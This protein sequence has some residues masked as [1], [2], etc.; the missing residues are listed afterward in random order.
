M[1]PSAVRK[2]LPRGVNGSPPSGR[3]CFGCPLPWSLGSRTIWS[4][5]LTPTHGASGSVHRRS[6]SGTRGCSVSPRRPDRA[7]WA[8]IVHSIIRRSRAFC[9]AASNQAI[10]PGECKKPGLSGDE[11]VLNER[12][13]ARQGQRR[14]RPRHGGLRA[15]TNACAVASPSARWGS[16]PGTRCASDAGGVDQ[17]ADRPSVRR[18]RGYGSFLAQRFQPRRCRSVEGERGARAGAGEERNGVARGDAVARGAG[19]RQAELD[20]CPQA[21]RNRGARG[22]S[23]QPLATVQ[24]AAK[25]SSGGGGPGTR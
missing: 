3:R 21:R 25:K 15:A 22:C 4:I 13:V 5:R 9:R 14:G 1:A 19:G 2:P 17:H 20:D 10:A 23:H 12:G 24:G 7:A 18:A 6:W 11:F 16:G 8:R